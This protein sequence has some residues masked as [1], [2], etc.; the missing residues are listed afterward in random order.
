[1][2]G[3]KP[4]G[5]W[6]EGGSKN[7][8]IFLYL[9]FFFSEELVVE[10]KKN[11]KFWEMLSSKDKYSSKNHSDPVIRTIL[12]Y[13]RS[14]PGSRDPQLPTLKMTEKEEVKGQKLYMRKIWRNTTDARRACILRQI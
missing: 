2:K 3:M 6:E 11:H 12:Q 14:C 8:R 1:M 9:D 13:I 10:P 5:C 7:I 4:I